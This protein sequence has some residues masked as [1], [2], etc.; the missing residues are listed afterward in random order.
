MKKAFLYETAFGE[1]GIAEENGSITHVFFGSTVRPDA[2]ELCETPILQQ[3]KAQLDAYFAGTLR[4][5]DLPLAPVG[6]EFERTVWEALRTIPYGETRSYGQIAAQIGSPNA[7][8]AVG[9][10]NGRNP[11]SI[12]VPCHRVIGASGT[13]TGYAGGLPMKEKL[14]TLERGQ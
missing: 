12:I 1:M 8:R 13:L 7:A 6:T 4:E 5:F 3:A 9:R 10:A 11:I 2:Y 14:L